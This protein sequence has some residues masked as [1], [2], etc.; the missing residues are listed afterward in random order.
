MRDSKVDIP[1]SIHPFGNSQAPLGLN[2][3]TELDG[4]EISGYTKGI[5]VTAG[6]IYEYR[7]SVG[8]IYWPMTLSCDFARKEIPTPTVQG[9]AT[10]TATITQTITPTPAPTL[11]AYVSLTFKSGDTNTTTTSPHPQVRVYNEGDSAIDLN[12]L[13]IRYYYQYEGTGQAEESYVDYAGKLP[14]GTYIGGNTH[15]EIISGSFGDSQDRY[16]KIT[17]DT[18]AGSLNTDDYVQ[19]E[20]RFNK[21]DWSQYDQS[22]DWSFYAV[23]NYESW[24]KVIVYYNGILVFGDE[25]GTYGSSS[26][27]ATPTP[28]RYEELSYENTYN[29]PN[30][31][32]DNTTIRF[33]V[34]QPQ[35]I[36]IIIYTT[37]GKEIWRKDMLTRQGINR[38]TWDIENKSGF[39]VSNGIYILKVI[40]IDKI[41]TKKIAV[42][43]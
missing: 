31:C 32:T 17:F 22:N 36:S 28:V 34:N 24:N 3:R 15:T 12:L 18:G 27:K 26:V 2:V 6:S 9:T 41:I 1:D 21:T 5:T 37:T 40:S 11:P 38:V 30:P 42:I 7:V 16:L 4:K 39:K 23:T 14:G 35:N 43:K 25:P 13:E 29:Y 33:L 19:A 20:T 10:V 8:N